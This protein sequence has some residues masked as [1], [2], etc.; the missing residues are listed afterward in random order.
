MESGSGSGSG[1]G[2][3]AT[4]RHASYNE[5]TALES[6]ISIKLY[7]A[8]QEDIL[9]VLYSFP[10]DSVSR[11]LF[12]IDRI[13]ALRRFS[14][15]DGILTDNEYYRLLYFIVN[16]HRF[17]ENDCN[18]A[19]IN[20]PLGY[21]S[22]GYDSPGYDST[23]N[24]DKLEFNDIQASLSIAVL[25][26]RYL[27]TIYNTILPQKVVKV[28][29]ASKQGKGKKGGMPPKFDPNPKRRNLDHSP[30][31]P[32]PS[33]MV[34]DD[35]SAD[36]AGGVGAFGIADVTDETDM[37]EA[38]ALDRVAGDGVAG[39]EDKYVG[40][41]RTGD[42]INELIQLSG[43][44]GHSEHIEDMISEDDYQAFLDKQIVDNN[45]IGKSAVEGK[46]Y[47][48]E[49]INFANRRASSR[50]AGRHAAIQEALKVAA[51]EA[52]KKKLSELA[53]AKAAADEAE[54]QLK[55]VLKT[56]GKTYSGI[57]VIPD[58]FVSYESD[59]NWEL[60][61]DPD[62][63]SEL[64]K[65]YCTLKNGCL[66]SIRAN[67]QN[68][69]AYV[70][71]LL[72]EYGLLSP[73][74]VKGFKDD[75]D[76]EEDTS[77]SG[78]AAKK[79]GGGKPIGQR[80][81]HPPVWP[82]EFK[83]AKPRDIIEGYVGAA[84]QCRQV[85]AKISEIPQ[86]K[87]YICGEIGLGNGMATMECEHIF[88]VGLAAQYYGLLRISG[89]SDTHKR[90][91]SILYAWAHRCCNQL[92]SNLSF[93]TLGP[94]NQFIFH[95]HNARELLSKIY[96]NNADFDCDA[97]N[98]VIR[99]KYGNNKSLFVQKRQPVL[100]RYCKPLID[101]VNTVRNKFFRS[102]FPLFVC[103]SKLHIMTK[104][105]IPLKKSDTGTLVLKRTDLVGMIAMVIPEVK[106]VGAAAA[107][108][109]GKGNIKK[110]RIQYGG[111]RTHEDALKDAIFEYMKWMV[112]FDNSEPT[113][114]TAATTA[115][116]A[117]P[118]TAAT[119]AS[120]AAV[121]VPGFD[122]PFISTTTVSNKIT[123][124]PL[125]ELDE[126]SDQNK[127]M[128]VLNA[129][130]NSHRMNPFI[131]IYQ[132]LFSD[133]DEWKLLLNDI[134]SV[135]SSVMENS[136]PLNRAT[137]SVLQLSMLA[138]E[139]DEFQLTS[140]QHRLKPQLTHMLSSF[141]DEY[142]FML[143]QVHKML[144]PSYDQ[145]TP[146]LVHKLCLIVYPDDLPTEFNRSDDAAVSEI[147]ED[148]CTNIKI[149][150]SLVNQARPIHLNVQIEGPQ[151]DEAFIDIPRAT[152]ELI[153]KNSVDKLKNFI[154]FY[155]NKNDEFSEVDETGKEV[156][157][158][159]IRSQVEHIR[160]NM[161]DHELRLLLSELAN[162]FTPVESS[163]SSATTVS[164]ERINSKLLPYVYCF[165]TAKSE[166]SSW[167]DLQ[168]CYAEIAQFISTSSV[169]SIGS[170]G[171]D[172]RSN[173]AGTGSPPYSPGGGSAMRH[174][175]SSIRTRRRS[176]LHRNHR[177]TQYT[178]KHK[179][180]L[181]SNSNKRS[182]IKHR[183]S[184]MKH[185]HTIK[186]RNGRRNNRK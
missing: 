158:S 36:D 12:N 170:N 40:Y 23:H 137:A 110:K 138:T 11:F 66:K 109:G 31:P 85:I 118:A 30:Q 60:V 136:G 114:A 180:Q 73:S 88:C 151:I 150:L 22:L 48:D 97:V 47:S 67:A 62:F 32:P 98:R 135:S 175:G 176:N 65:K 39:D 45:T 116:A 156:A 56:A 27:F 14:Q 81:G 154:E 106:I 99:G 4:G 38:S 64:A 24:F 18:I 113:L 144:S 51:D 75:D 79:K 107:A 55:N 72:V 155:I 82:E 182:S 6:S 19:S 163:F 96:S 149:F 139:K 142:S 84:S 90:I 17:V 179:H 3:V 13:Q 52:A 20:Q 115:S 141:I 34:V 117:T 43:E 169:S 9:M 120:S 143:Q 126:V 93:M 95:E 53:A 1:S 181:S 157:I 160:Q 101:E 103:M 152:Y 29:K 164:S 146:E 140:E 174:R 44:I 68:D 8:N 131:L 69:R 166:I 122:F 16:I 5:T 123:T 10:Q 46:P 25:I 147:V 171:S 173:L 165:Y 87:C 28:V 129:M 108:G 104:T 167:N 63:V 119:P 128:F 83:A 134:L 41:T 49:I 54:E 35:D 178:N 111:Q 127:N 112:N 177:R 94:Q 74:R 71:R 168:R 124:T 86:I 80:G 105:L 2:A 185:T 132:L 33:D 77:G 78:A 145:L 15:L 92:K 161:S 21:D 37:P 70:V 58:E 59:K 57:Q 172:A 184:H 159:R 91:L 100:G 148:I 42:E 153:R 133:G 50:V 186:R 102:N 76:D 162:V 125:P 183:K 89:L 7:Y 61:S 26:C 130:V 121:P